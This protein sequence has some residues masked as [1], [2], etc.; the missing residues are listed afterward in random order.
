MDFFNLTKYPPSLEFMLLTLGVDLLLVFLLS[1][2]ET[3]L[4]SWGT[5]LVL[6]GS[7]A[8]FF[9]IAHLYLYALMGLAF[10]NGTSFGLM[11]CL[12][13]AGLVLLYP[14]CLWYRRFKEQKLPDSVW[15]FF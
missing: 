3:Q 9:Y 15:R 8:L 14:L 7:T 11:Y 2:V 5:F 6:F 1:K 13:F 12:W 10:P 4:Q